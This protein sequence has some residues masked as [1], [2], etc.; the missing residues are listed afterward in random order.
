VF[1]TGFGGRVVP[2]YIVSRYSLAHR[3]A[4][5]LSNP[6]RMPTRHLFQW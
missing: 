1:Y 5:R 3:I 4:G 6:F 2:R